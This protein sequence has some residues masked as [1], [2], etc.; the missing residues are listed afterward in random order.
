[1]RATE[2]VEQREQLLTNSR[3]VFRSYPSFK[4]FLS[5]HHGLSSPYGIL[6]LDSHYMNS[7]AIGQDTLVGLTRSLYLRVLLDLLH[8]SLFPCLHFGQ[9]IAGVT[10]VVRISENAGKQGVVEQV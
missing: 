10:R 3:V 7:C 1:M 8:E 4:G 5:A 2:A 9:L 6:Y